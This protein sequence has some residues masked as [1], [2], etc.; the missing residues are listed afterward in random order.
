MRKFVTVLLMVAMLSMP[1]RFA[2]ANDGGGIVVQNIVSAFSRPSGF[3]S[4]LILNMAVVATVF[5][6][7]IALLPPAQ[8]TR[9][10]LAMT[11]TLTAIYL[12]NAIA[13]LTRYFIYSL[14]FQI[15]YLTRMSPANAATP[16][17]AQE[18]LWSA[19]SPDVI[20]KAEPAA[21]E[22]TKQEVINEAVAAALRNPQVAQNY[23]DYATP[24]VK[25]AIE[26]ALADRSRF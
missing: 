11:L 2:A 16:E 5:S 13:T 14:T 12:R 10:T 4:I 22:K 8:R 26:K 24:E 15:L 20:A 23:L 6:P 21:K 17:A 3:L 18:G 7:T 25:A 19:S 9:F 1:G